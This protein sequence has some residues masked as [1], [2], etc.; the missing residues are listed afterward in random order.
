MYAFWMSINDLISIDFPFKFHV[1]IPILPFPQITNFTVILVYLL[2][3]FKWYLKERVDVIYCLKEV[4]ELN[5][6]SR[7]RSQGGKD[8]LT[9]FINNCFLKWK[10]G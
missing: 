1:L 3:I 10:E 4:N 2:Y 8:A 7:I 9:N 6:L 5:T